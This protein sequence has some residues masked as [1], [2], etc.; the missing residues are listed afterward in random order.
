[1]QKQAEARARLLVEEAGDARSPRSRGV[2]SCFVRSRCQTAQAVHLWQGLACVVQMVVMVL[3]VQFLSPNHGVDYAHVRAG[4]VPLRHRPSR[5]TGRKG[6]A[7]PLESVSIGSW[8][9]ALPTVRD[10]ACRGPSP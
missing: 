10:H 1:M 3:Q 9:T 4:P 7:W 8:V 5:R 6:A 2:N